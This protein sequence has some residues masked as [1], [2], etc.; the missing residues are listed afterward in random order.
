MTD[1]VERAR[2]ESIIHWPRV[3]G[4]HCTCGS[5]LPC[6]TTELLA[7]VERL[8]AEV[9][10]ARRLSAVDFERARAADDVLE[11]ELVKR[12]KV[13]EE[14]DEVRAEV[15]RLREENT[16]LRDRLDHGFDVDQ[17]RRLEKA[18]AAIQRVRDLPGTLYVNHLKP[19]VDVR[20]ILAALDGES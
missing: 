9:A 15:E 18:E 20:D 3:E 13:I 10:E 8:R 7:E 11:E 6:I 16:D 19:V 12:G 2:R 17:W 14:R 4:T 1:V 5:R